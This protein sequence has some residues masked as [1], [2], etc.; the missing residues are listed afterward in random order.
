MHMSLRLNPQYEKLLPK[1]SDEEF[2][3][4]KA[5]IQAEGQHYAIK[6]NED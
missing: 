6:V 4:L 1:M 2:A 5:S 3:E